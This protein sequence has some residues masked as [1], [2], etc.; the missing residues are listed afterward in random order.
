MKSA[1]FVSTI[2]TTSVRAFFCCQRRKLLNVNRIFPVMLL[3]LLVAACD[4]PAPSLSAAESPG[5]A[6]SETCRECHAPQFD[7]WQ[8]S[9][10]ALAMQEVTSE[11]VLG[12]FSGVEFQYFDV[13]STFFKGDGN[14]LEIGRA[15]CRERV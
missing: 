12:D 8:D 5:F 14:F 2:A 11:S 15:S 6:G 13:T 7:L 3:G 1:M 4:T 10:H 9:H